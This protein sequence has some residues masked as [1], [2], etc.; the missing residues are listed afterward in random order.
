MNKQSTTKGFAVLSTAGMLV[1]VI[2]LLYVPFLLNILGPQGYGVYTAAYQIFGFVYVLTNSGIPVA[3][4]KTIS[5]LVAVKNYKDAVKSFKIARFIMV[6]IGFIMSVALFFLAKPICNLAHMERSYLAVAALAPTIFL[7]SV[8]SVYRGYFQGRG[9]MVPTA[10]SQVVEQIANT[11]FSLLFAA[12]FIK[13][14]AEAGSAG[15]TVGT[16]IG[17]FLATSILLIVYEKNKKFKVK[18]YDEIPEKRYTSEQLLKRVVGCGVPITLCVALQNAGILVD[19]GNITRRLAVAGF[20]SNRIEVLY[21]IYGKYNTLVGVPIALISALSAA[22]LPAISGAVA[23]KDKTLV[24]NKIRHAFR[25]CFL[26]AVP[27]AVGLAVLSKPIFALLHFGEGYELMM[28]GSIV[29]I[30]WSI[31][32][33]QTTILQSVGKLYVVILYL[34]IGIVGKIATNYILVSIKDINITGAV[35]GSAICFAIPLIL[36]NRK[37]KKELK[38]DFSLLRQMKKALIAS[39][40]MGII[41]KICYEIINYVLAFIKYAYVVNGIATVISVIIGGIIY[42]YVLVYI[43]GIKEEDLKVLPYR[44]RKFIPKKVRRK[45]V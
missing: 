19:M 7:T 18:S 27:S 45:K 39:I 8:L 22:V 28:Y 13:Y 37:I 40:A 20:D 6:S 24:K 12:V 2:S 31:V 32:Q 23:I 10:V 25:L 17:A 14:G 5:E 15:G 11:I 4:S 35:F 3:V 21:G 9:N 26:V 41:V 43:G 16:V 44:I 1:K 34:G 36:N 42:V 29:V 38:I 33:I 30:L